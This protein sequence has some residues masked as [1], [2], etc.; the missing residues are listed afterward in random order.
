MYTKCFK[1]CILST[2]PS[3]EKKK[4]KQN[5]RAKLISIKIVE[6]CFTYLLLVQ[7]N[8]IALNMSLNMEE[9]LAWHWQRRY[10]VYNQAFTSAHKFACSLNVWDAL[11][12][13]WWENNVYTHYS[14][15]GN[16][17]GV[18]VRPLFSP[19]SRSSSYPSRIRFIKCLMC[20][21]GKAKN[22]GS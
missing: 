15:E 20:I 8:V 11:L 16:H 22:N 2:F 19:A 17:Q 18:S 12:V 4:G 1:H 21:G 13:R 14:W 10:A 9:S 6:I 7:L 3:S 5:P